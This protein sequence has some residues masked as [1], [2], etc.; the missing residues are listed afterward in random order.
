MYVKAPMYEG[1]ASGIVPNHRHRLR[2][3]TFV[4]TTNQAKGRAKIVAH[5]VANRAS[6]AV[7]KANVAR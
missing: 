5:V 1:M 7:L 6:D 4:R 3:G 2:Q